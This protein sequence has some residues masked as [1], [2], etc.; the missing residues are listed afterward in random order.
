MPNPS[1]RSQRGYDR[2]A[3]SYHS[4]EW[5]AFGSQLQLAR[6]ALIDQ[7]P[8]WQRLLIYGDGN[9]RLLEQ[10]Y[11]YRCTYETHAA[12]TELSSA[13]ERTVP[14][15]SP[16]SITSVDHSPAMLRRQQ[17][18][19]AATPLRNGPRN[20]RQAVAPGGATRFIQIDALNYTPE[21]N[22]YDVVVTPFFLDCFSQSE[23]AQHLPI[24]LSALREDGTL[25]HVDFIVP[26]SPWQRPRA[27][28]L[29]WAMHT[30]F[31]WQTGLANRQL[32]DSQ[33]AI[34]RC[35]L[36]KT[37]EHISSQGMIAAQLWRFTR[38]CGYDSNSSQEA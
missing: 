25:L 18:R 21:E 37:A 23:L 30:F 19:L 9:G 38:A 12:P 14:S 24:W 8:V 15:D 28:L 4:L 33:K 32:V 36:R 31:R 20:E 11:A 7:L 26:Q 10:L 2:L 29:L 1:T 16:W 27:H 3:H 22:A 6:V 13:C 34:E 17:S 5:L 35:G